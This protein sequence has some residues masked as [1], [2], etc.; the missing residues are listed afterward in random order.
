MVILKISNGGK[1][2]ESTDQINN[3]IEERGQGSINRNN[4]NA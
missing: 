2:N 4:E 1:K 3:R